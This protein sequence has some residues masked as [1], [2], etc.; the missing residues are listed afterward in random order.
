VAESDRD[1]PVTV[2][3]LTL[4]ASI[5]PR[6]FIPAMS[7]VPDDMSEYGEIISDDATLEMS[8]V[9][10]YDHAEDHPRLFKGEP[11]EHGYAFCTDNEEHPWVKIDLGAVKTVKAL[12]IENRHNERC[13]NGLL[14]FA[15]EDGE[16]WDKVW[17]AEEWE[18]TWCAVVTHFHAGIEVPGRKVRYL[19]LQ[20]HGQKKRHLLLQRVT[21]HGG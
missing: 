8:S 6:T 18:P 20:T 16:S 21:V 3:E 2:I 15:S 17:E 12:L 1:T 19:M 5:A 4:D 9:S 11:S 14:L 7:S 13:T 10:E